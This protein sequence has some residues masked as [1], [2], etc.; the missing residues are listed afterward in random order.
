[1]CDSAFR[2]A[3]GRRYARSSAGSRRLRVSASRESPPRYFH[4]AH[5]L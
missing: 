2:Q 1:M 5:G 3:I 4:R